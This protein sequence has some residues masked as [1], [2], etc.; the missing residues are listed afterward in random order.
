MKSYRSLSPYGFATEKPNWLAFH[1]NASSASAPLRFDVHSIALEGSPLMVHLVSELSVLTFDEKHGPK[2]APQ[3]P[4]PFEMCECRIRPH[5]TNKKARPRRR[6]AHF[7]IL[8]LEY[9]LTHTKCDTP[10]VVISPIES[11][12]CVKNVKLSLLTSFR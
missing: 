3:A 12:I 8:V 2:P 4:F 10:G 7:L 1:K 11:S 6:A 9:Q 5:A